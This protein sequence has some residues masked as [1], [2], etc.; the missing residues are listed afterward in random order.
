MRL[1]SYLD[2]G[3][4]RLGLASGDRVLAAMELVT[5]GPRTLGE[6]F[7]GG[8]GMNARITTGAEASLERIAR[9]GTR[10]S[11]LQL[12]APVPRPGKVVAIGLNYHAHAAEQ[13]IEAPKQPLIFA[14]FPTSVVGHRA[15]VSWDPTLTRKVDYEAELA[16]VIGRRAR[17]VSEASALD[18]VLGYTCANDVTARDLQ[19]GDGQWVRGK[20]LDT[21]CP[22]G[23]VLVT[24]DEIDDPQALAISCSVNGEQVQEASTADMI[25]SVARLVSFCSAAFTLEPG[26]VIVTGTPPGVGLYR[27]PQRFLQDGDEVTV[28]IEGIGRLVNVCRVEAED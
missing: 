18:Y 26:D 25:F 8:T 24:T 20:S 11:D 14:K 28:E 3:A 15:T 16:V 1:V 22:L 17:N 21:F 4:E 23:P 9:E 19:R 13:G 12:L 6:L 2:H 27:E 7:A 5:G 10:M